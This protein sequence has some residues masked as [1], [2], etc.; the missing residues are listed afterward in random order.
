MPT[1]LELRLRGDHITLDQLLKATGV[2]DSGGQAKAMV[3]AG[4]VAVDGR[5]ELRK[6]CK[7]HAG[8]VVTLA[9]VRIR[10]LGMD[11]AAAPVRAPRAGPARARPAFKPRAAKPGPGGGGAD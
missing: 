1:E 4:G 9:D 11:D 2:A 7:L 8:Q 5:Q 6:T 3:A 10:V